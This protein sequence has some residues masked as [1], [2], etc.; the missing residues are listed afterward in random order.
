V[1]AGWQGTAFADAVRGNAISTRRHLVFGQGAHTDPRAVRTRDHLYIRTYHR[2]CFRAERESLF[3]VTADPSLTRNVVEDEPALADAMR[4]TARRVV[5][6][7]RRASRRPA[8]PD[9]DHPAAGTDLQQHPG[10][11]CAASA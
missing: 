9:A 3:D 2:R 5:D 10:P 6:G 8:E 11:V 7:A 1:A 4:A